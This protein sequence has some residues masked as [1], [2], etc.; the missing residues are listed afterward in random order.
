MTA[1]DVPPMPDPTWADSE[2]WADAP[3]AFREKVEAVVRANEAELEYS[4]F[5]DHA[6]PHRIALEEASAAARSALW[7]WVREDRERAIAEARTSLVNA[8][9]KAAT[10]LDGSDQGETSVLLGSLLPDDWETAAL[11]RG[12]DTKASAT[13]A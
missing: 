2:T 9:H 12:S 11:S 4:E 7:A 6:V 10:D 8:M 13:D 5:G 1:A 3:P